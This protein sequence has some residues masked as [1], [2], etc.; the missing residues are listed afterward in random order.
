MKSASRNKSGDE[1]TFSLILMSFEKSLLEKLLEKNEIYD[2]VV[3]KFAN[4][5]DTLF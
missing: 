4:K 2:F 1:K 3:E 5:L